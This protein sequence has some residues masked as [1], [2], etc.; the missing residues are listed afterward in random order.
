[1][2]SDVKKKNS[3]PSKLAV[4]QQQQQLPNREPLTTSGRVSKSL[5]R[6]GRSYNDQPR[7]GRSYNDQSRAEVLGFVRSNRDSSEG[8]THSK[9]S[10][11]DY[12]EYMNI[13]NRVRGTKEFSRVRTEQ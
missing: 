10:D 3:A 1:M 6:E 7:E 4:N 2:G 13:I 12:Q 8:A 9:N 11:M 5:P